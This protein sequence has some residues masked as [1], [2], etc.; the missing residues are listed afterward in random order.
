MPHP[1]SN[2][3]Q[4]IA[5][6]TGKNQKEFTQNIEIPPRNHILTERDDDSALNDD[7]SDSIDDLLSK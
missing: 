1:Q 5:S 3:H 7:D 4:R 6:I 2:Q